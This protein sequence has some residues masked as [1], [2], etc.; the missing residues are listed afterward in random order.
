MD[1]TN[2]RHQF[3]GAPAAAATRLVLQNHTFRGLTPTAK[4]FR[5]CAARTRLQVLALP[6]S[7]VH[8]T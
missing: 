7:G 8:L 6:E 4:R 1:T 2:S 5:R 3:I